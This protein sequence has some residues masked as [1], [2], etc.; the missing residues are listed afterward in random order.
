MSTVIH[1][2]QQTGPA[3]GAPAA[4]EPATGRPGIDPRGPR[5]VASLTAVLLAVALLAS[6]PITIALLA[7]QAVVFAIGAFRGI[8]NT[9]YSWLFRAFVRPRLA[10]P[11]ELEDPA[12]PRFAQTV[13]LAFSVVALAGYLSGLPLL[14]AIA[15]GAALA[16]AFLN[17]AFGFCLGCEL[18]LLIKRVRG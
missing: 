10:P 13:G 16:A 2:H 12:P 17:A 3:S 18:Y 15:T 14:G 7:A 8:Q 11:H 4:Q 6:P 9:P 1:P 5:F